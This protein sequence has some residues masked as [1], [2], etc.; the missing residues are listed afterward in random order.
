[1]INLIAFSAGDMASSKSGLENIS[2][3]YLSKDLH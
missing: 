3:A 1:M 2:S